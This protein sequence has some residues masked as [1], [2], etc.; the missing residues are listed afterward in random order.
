M[1]SPR[2]LRAGRLALGVVVL[3]L[4]TA[5]AGALV[6]TNDTFRAGHLFDRAVAKVDRFLAGPV[7]ERSAPVTVVVPEASH[8]AAE[9][10][11]D[12]VDPSAEATGSAMPPTTRAASLPT[13][14][15]AP[16][17]TAVPAPVSK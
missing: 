6:V 3:A 9:L 11:P 4:V 16:S 12:E 1:T 14:V 17:V 13:P 15:A 5:V 7:P 2:R 8:D 10:D